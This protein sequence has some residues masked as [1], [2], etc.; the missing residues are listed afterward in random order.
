MPIYLCPKCRKEFTHKGHYTEHLNRKFKCSDTNDYQENASSLST[1]NLGANRGND[2]LKNPFISRKELGQNLKISHYD[3]SYS[4]VFE[5][6][7][8]QS[9]S[10]SSSQ[11]NGIKMSYDNTINTQKSKNSTNDTT[12][13]CIYC[14]TSLKSRSSFNRHI[15]TCKLVPLTKSDI[16]DIEKTVI[17]KMNNNIPLQKSKNIQNINNTINSTTNNTQNIF[18]VDHRIIDEKNINLNAFGKEQLDYISKDLLKNIISRPESG[19]IKLI[20]HVHFND[21][22]PENQNVIIKNKSDPYLE[23]FNGEKWEKYDKKV[24]IQNIIST[25]KDIMDDYFDE[26][27]EK[28]I[29]STFI[30]K[31]YE[32]FSTM[33]DEHVKQSLNNYDDKIRSHVVSKCLKWYKEIC[34][35][36]E[37]LI[38]NNRKIDVKQLDKTDVELLEDLE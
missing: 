19:I 20:E 38:L 33:L 37:L 26:Q 11:K 14:Q 1:H 25:K 21:D 22:Q 8:H 34:K 12:L 9:L 32:T 17:K 7:N 27:V 31:N 5:K 6:Q 23:I 15:K 10:S 30:K 29:L 4:N 18:Y 13:K 2:V 16:I 24:A 35:Q 36:A 3:N 28:N